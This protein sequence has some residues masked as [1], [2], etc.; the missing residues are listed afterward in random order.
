MLG[1]LISVAA[2][3]A[4]PALEG[5]V[6]RPVARAIGTNIELK[7]GELRVLAF[8]LAMV[9]AAILCAVFSSG[10][11]LGLAV[12]GMIGYFGTRLVQWFNRTVRP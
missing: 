9:I 10:S 8:M 1:F 6:A 11:P 2:G 7:D 5:P 4:T 12:G 3:F